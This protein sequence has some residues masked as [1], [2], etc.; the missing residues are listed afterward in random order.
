MIFGLN[1]NLFDKCMTI[2]KK[3]RGSKEPVS[4]NA[5]QEAGRYSEGL[6]KFLGFNGG[7]AKNKVMT[8]RQEK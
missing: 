5:G 2:R 7:F 1:D 6:S 3:A 8:R 4:T